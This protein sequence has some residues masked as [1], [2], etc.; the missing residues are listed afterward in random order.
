[1]HMF[2]ISRRLWGLRSVRSAILSFE[3]SKL[4]MDARSIDLKVKITV[5]RHWLLR[6][7]GRNGVLRVSDK[8]RSAE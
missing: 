2:I 1:M 4:W 8:T 6:L 3:E 5:T 7:G